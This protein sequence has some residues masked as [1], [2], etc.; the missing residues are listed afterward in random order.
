MR[1]LVLLSFYLLPSRMSHKAREDK[2]KT[3]R[4]RLEK[5]WTALHFSFLSSLHA[6]VRPGDVS[7]PDRQHGY[8]SA[9]TCPEQRG[10]SEVGL[11]N[12][13]THTHT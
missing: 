7:E 5:N 6:G 2:I 1:K 13:D 11:H 9:E 3:P 8:C 4:C 10:T 12:E